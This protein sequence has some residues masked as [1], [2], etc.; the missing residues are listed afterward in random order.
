VGAELGLN[1]DEM[2]LYDALIDHG[3]VMRKVKLLIREHGYLLD[4]Q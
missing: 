4:K 3:N 1:E 2:A